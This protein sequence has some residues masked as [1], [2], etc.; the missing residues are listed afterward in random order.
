MNS[1]SNI[2]ETRLARGTTWCAALVLCLVAA[3]RAA[4]AQAAASRPAEPGDVQIKVTQA[5]TQSQMISVPVNQSALVDFSVDVKEVRVTNPEIADV[6]AMSTRQLLVKGKS[7]G[8][9]QLI[10]TV[11]GGVQRVF[12]ITV[13]LDMERLQASIR[14]T[15]PQA[16]VT[17]SALMDRVV[18]AGTVPD[19][20]SAERIMQIARIYSG[21]VINHMRVA[22]VQQVLLRCTVAEVNRTATRQLGFSG[23]MAGDNVPDMFTVSQ[24]DGINPVNIG[25]AGGANVQARIPFLTDQNGL[26]LTATPTLSLGFPRVQ[27]QIFIKALRENGLLKVLAEPNLVAI[28]GQEANFLAGGEIPYPVAQG[29]ASNAISIE[30]REY[31]V[32]LN[33]TP[34]VLGPSTIR[35][36]VVPEVSE[37]DFSTSVTLGGFV[38]P[39]LIQRRVETTV[40]LGA[41]QT[42]AIGG[43]L[44]EK[45]RAVSK[46]VPALGDVPVLGALFSSVQYQSNETELV[47]LVTPELVEPL[48]PDQV[49][50][51]PG[52]DHVPPNDW[53]LFGLG[54][55]EGATATGEGAVVGSAG[56]PGRHAGEAGH[57]ERA[58]RAPTAGKSEACRV[59][60]PIGP[61]GAEEGT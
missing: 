51:I 29:G 23:W 8:T 30:Y 2:T 18:I 4:R 27:M 16:K 35:L 47:V 26:P 15:A 22:G 13:D 55:I 53:E 19:T 12:T 25:A 34:T 60:G 31:G 33:F 1:Q 50:Y 59:R 57:T 61:A 28:S 44:S 17:A 11:D 6:D 10:A 41:G 54:Q 20:E 9:T 3:P 43:L 45:A 39:G 5:K 42:F 24:L 32:R 49:A 7:F 46:K 36:H 37:P 58:H 38:V 40:E 56:A 52:A 48:S 14:T 21:Q